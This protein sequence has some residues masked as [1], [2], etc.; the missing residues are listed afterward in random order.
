MHN[1]FS[2]YFIFQAH[3]ILFLGKGKGKIPKLEK[4]EVR[5]VSESKNGTEQEEE[6]TLY[7]QPSKHLEVLSP[8][9]KKEN[10]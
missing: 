4:T 8:V 3:R 7:M 10:Y 9:I 1:V 2:K 5:N 6:R